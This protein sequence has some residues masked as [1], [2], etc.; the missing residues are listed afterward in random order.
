ML[1]RDAAAGVDE[2]TWREYQEGLN[3]RLIDLHERVQSGRY[4]AQPS[5][6][7]YI[8]KSDG[9]QR[10]IGIAALEDK[11]VQKA[12]VR[13]L[14]QIYEEQ[15]LGFSYGFRP[16]RSQHQAL[17]AIWVGITRRHIRWILDADLQS[18]FDTLDHEWMMEFLQHRIADRRMLRMIRKWLRAGVSEEGTWSKTTVGTPQGAVIS[19]LLANIFLHYAFDLWAHQWR[20]QEGHGDVIIVRYAD[21]FVVGFERRAEAAAFRAALK[22]RLRSI[23]RPKSPRTRGLQ[24]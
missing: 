7:I 10:P 14:E 6:R 16:G 3:G 15:F 18:F 17:D 4:R 19:P 23:R 8:A 13:I 9:R 1:K 11:I 5:K 22:E 12:T 20:Q 24:A 2:M 21:D